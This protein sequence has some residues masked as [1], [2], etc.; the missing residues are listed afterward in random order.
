[1]RQ[2]KCFQLRVFVEEVESVW[3]TVEEIQV[4]VHGSILCSQWM[5]LLGR[6]L[7]TVAGVAEEER[8]IK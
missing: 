3:T 7:T 5:A 1:M 2:G 4:C 6:D 8:K